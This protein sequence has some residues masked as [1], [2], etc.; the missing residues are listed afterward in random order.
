MRV[1]PLSAEHFDAAVE[2]AARC[3][4]DEWSDHAYRELDASLNGPTPYPNY[5]F[6]VWESEKLISLGVILTEWFRNN[7]YS[8][9]WVCTHPSHRK[10]G[11]GRMMAEH[12]LTHINTLFVTEQ[13][14]VILLS[15]EK[16]DFYKNFGFNV[17][18]G[19]TNDWKLMVKEVRHL[20]TSANNG[21]L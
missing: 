2:L 3:F 9:S 5:V 12:C 19:H 15:T 16:H 4:G 21:V 18:A 11:I 6:G 7:T 1:T 17:V 20:E 10:Q 13:V 14:G 8:L